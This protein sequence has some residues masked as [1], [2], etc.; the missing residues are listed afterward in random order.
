MQNKEFMK[1]IKKL[2]SQILGLKRIVRSYEELV[3]KQYQILRI[4]QD[5]MP[6][7]FLKY[8]RD[9][10]NKERITDSPLKL[11]FIDEIK[12]K[13]YLL[14]IISDETDRILEEEQHHLIDEFES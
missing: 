8:M 7:G 11:E 14:Q 6:V 12:M 13:L 10:M 3:D 2:K 9:Q 1:N 4:Y 5:N